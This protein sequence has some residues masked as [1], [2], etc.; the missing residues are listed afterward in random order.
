MPPP[1]GWPRPALSSTAA[2]A[3]GERRH[4]G[5]GGIGGFDEE[6]VP[7]DGVDASL[8]LQPVLHRRLDEL[9]A[10][11]LRAEGGT[12]E[13]ISG[14][15]ASVDGNICLMLIESGASLAPK[16]HAPAASPVKR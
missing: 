8:Q 13:H 1:F 9:G 4:V 5:A 3:P 12:G 6:G 10:R 2:A 14:C 7:V 16:G 11:T 15:A